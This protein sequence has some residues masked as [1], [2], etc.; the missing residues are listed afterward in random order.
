MSIDLEAEGRA[1]MERSR[2]WSRLAST[3]QLDSIL[4]GWAEDAVVMPPGLPPIEGKGAIRQYVEAALRLPGFTISWEP[5]SV[6]VAKSGDLAYLIERNKSTMNDST[7]KPV[8]TYGKVVT[9]W[10]KDSTG[11]WRN[12]VDMWNDAPPPGA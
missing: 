12:V 1:V 6:H 9:V 2:D 10:R 11:T 3:G 8:T 4:D 7:G 5:V